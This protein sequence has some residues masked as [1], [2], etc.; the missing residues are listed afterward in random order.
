M[1]SP[2]VRHFQELT[3][4][5]YQALQSGTPSQPC[6]RCYPATTLEDQ[7]EREI[8]HAGAKGFAYGFGYV[9][10]AGLAIGLIAIGVAIIAPAAVAAAA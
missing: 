4:A 6:C 1:A 3:E 8:D 5:E 10:G 7:R 9:F 2:T